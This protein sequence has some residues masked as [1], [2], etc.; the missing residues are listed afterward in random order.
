[1]RG[2]DLSKGIDWCSTMR[3]NSLRDRVLVDHLRKQWSG[4]ELSHEYSY[5]GEHPDLGDSVF[6]STPVQRQSMLSW[7]SDPHIY[8]QVRLDVDSERDGV[9]SS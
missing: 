1:M 2:T 4:S 9:V 5:L 3:C 6:F 7:G 8:R